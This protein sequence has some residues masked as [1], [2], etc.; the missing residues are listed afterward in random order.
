[1]FHPGQRV[2][3]LPV[4]DNYEG[5]PPSGTKGTIV[6]VGESGHTK[7]VLFDGYTEKHWI[8]DDFLSLVYRVPVFYRKRVFLNGKDLGCVRAD[9][10]SIN[11]AVR[12]CFRDNR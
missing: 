3:V 4:A 5:Y 2:R 12:R 11:R 7:Q 10:R 8:C 6:R 1:M 9:I